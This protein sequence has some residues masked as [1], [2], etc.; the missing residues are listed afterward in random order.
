[1]IFLTYSINTDDNLNKSL[2]FLSSPFNKQLPHPHPTC[3]KSPTVIQKSSDIMT[4]LKKRNFE[5]LSQSP[6][7]FCS[8]PLKKLK[9]TLAPRRYEE[10]LKTSALVAYTIHP[11]C[12]LPTNVIHIHNFILQ[13][14]FVP[15]VCHS[16]TKL[17]KS[18]H[19][20]C[21]FRHQSYR[22]I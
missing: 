21:T 18:N 1:M 14:H 17:Q 12:S 8:R 9:E 19:V 15:L 22:K 2:K 6:E 13:N 20:K 16:L 4:G 3:P 5:R 10:W 11:N 7:H